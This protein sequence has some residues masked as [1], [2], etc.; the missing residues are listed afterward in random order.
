MEAQCGSQEPAQSDVEEDGIPVLG[1]GITLLLESLCTSLVTK[2]EDDSAE[3]SK[4]G[5]EGL[6]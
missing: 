2:K 6:N 3:G 1:H 4:L 5:N